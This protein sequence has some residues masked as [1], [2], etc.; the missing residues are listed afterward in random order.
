MRYY[1]FQE[2]YKYRRSENKMDYNLFS[3][4]CGKVK[5]IDMGEEISLIYDNFP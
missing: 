4:D 2:L 1:S 3:I 5:L